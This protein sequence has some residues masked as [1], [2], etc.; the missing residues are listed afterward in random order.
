MSNVKKYWNGRKRLISDL[1][2]SGVI[3]FVL[4]L[5]DKDVLPSH[6]AL[7]EFLGRTVGVFFLFFFWTWNH[8][9]IK[10]RPARYVIHTFFG[11]LVIGLLFSLA[12]DI[13]LEMDWIPFL[14]V[15]GYL[16]LVARKYIKLMWPRKTRKSRLKLKSKRSAVMRKKG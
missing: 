16:G 11:F 10:Y 6:E 4:A 5:G 15:L 14:I 1:L 13:F 2:W 7:I 9:H 3:S 12:M 8:H